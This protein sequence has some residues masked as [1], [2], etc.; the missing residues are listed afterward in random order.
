MKQNTEKWLILFI[1]ITLW[2]L[3]TILSPRSYN[4]YSTTTGGKT[5]ILESNI[6]WWEHVRE[7]GFIWKKVLTKDTNEQ[8][9]CIV[10]PQDKNSF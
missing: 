6:L 4:C 2:L 5:S 9:K 1:V 7:K 3:I 8:Y 10:G